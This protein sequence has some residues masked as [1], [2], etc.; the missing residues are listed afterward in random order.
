MEDEGEPERIILPM[1]GLEELG[2]RVR[3]IGEKG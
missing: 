2:K 3:G 1:G